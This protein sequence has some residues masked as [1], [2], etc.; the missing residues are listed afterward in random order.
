MLNKTKQYVGL[1]VRENQ[2]GKNTL[3]TK[4][5]MIEIIGY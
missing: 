4:S 2:W 3:K 1:D 5:H